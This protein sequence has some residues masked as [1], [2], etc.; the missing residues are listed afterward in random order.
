[1]SSRHH[2]C[3]M[4]WGHDLKITLNF[5]AVIEPKQTQKENINFGWNTNGK[6]IYSTLWIYAGLESI[7]V[8]DFSSLSLNSCRT[9][10]LC[11]LVW[12]L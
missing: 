4:H 8:S 12:L 10:I 2:H 6:K 5:K 1:M 11:Y 9:Q 7:I 3:S